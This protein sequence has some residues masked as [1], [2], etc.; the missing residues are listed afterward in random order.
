MVRAIV[1]AIGMLASLHLSRLGLNLDRIDWSDKASLVQHGYYQDVLR[2]VLDH[3]QAGEF[4]WAGLVMLASVLV[5]AWP[6]RRQ[7]RAARCG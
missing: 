4:V 5:L 3:A 6:P 7:E 1:G 2:D